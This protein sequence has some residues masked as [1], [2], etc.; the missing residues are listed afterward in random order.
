MA[1]KHWRGLEHIG[2]IGRS[3]EWFSASLAKQTQS[4]SNRTTDI[5]DPKDLASIQSIIKKCWKIRLG[6]LERD[7]TR[8]AESA[9]FIILPGPFQTNLYTRKQTAQQNITMK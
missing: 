4:D 5:T 8:T 3:P 9:S 6:D 2:A 1:R 7:E